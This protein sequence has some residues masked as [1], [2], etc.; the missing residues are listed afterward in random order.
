[1]LS[2]GITEQVIVTVETGPKA[3][4]VDRATGITF[5]RNL[6]SHAIIITLSLDALQLIVT[7]KPEPLC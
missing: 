2:T 3:G 5:E 4:N 7:M 1:M 6:T